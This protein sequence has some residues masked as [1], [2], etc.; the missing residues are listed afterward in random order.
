MSGEESGDEVVAVGVLVGPVEGDVD[1]SG[2][3]G[4]LSHE[5]LLVDFEAEGADVE[6]VVDAHR[7]ESFQGKICKS[8]SK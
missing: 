6:E 3:G 2:L 1:G 8:V 5:A 4:V 7:N